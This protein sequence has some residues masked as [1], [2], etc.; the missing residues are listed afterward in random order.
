M[1]HAKVNVDYCVAF[2]HRLY[3]VP[4]ALVG[5][6][7]EI[8]A[9]V[10]VV[11]VLHKGVRVASHGRSFAPK[12]TSVIADEHRPRAHRDYGRWPP[13]RMVA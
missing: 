7:V 11:E 12:G 2:D 8:R 6:A 5:Q 1:G 3:S 9:T 4:Y 13:E 10:R